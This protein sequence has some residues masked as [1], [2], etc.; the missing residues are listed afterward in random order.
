MQKL[1]QIF[2]FSDKLDHFLINYVTK[3]IKEIQYPDS[4]FI[5]HF[6][7]TLIVNLIHEKVLIDN[8]SDLIPFL[9][10]I[11]DGAGIHIDPTQYKTDAQNQMICAKL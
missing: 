10:S 11:N 3:Q 8:F 2:D 7:Y 1:F 9:I 5:F 6:F 4:L